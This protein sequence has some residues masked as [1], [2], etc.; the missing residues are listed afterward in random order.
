MPIATVRQITSTRY[1]LHLS[2]PGS[3]RTVRPRAVAWAGERLLPT[4]VWEATTSSTYTC[5][6][7]AGRA[8][9]DGFSKTLERSACER[10]Q[11]T[12]HSTTTT[13]TR[14]TRGAH[15]CHSTACVRPW[16][17]STTTPCR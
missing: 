14:S 9:T 2:S 11:V 13:T 5:V 3:V 4:P 1:L 6:I 17:T 16:H 15:H 12:S 8:I 7:L 10:C